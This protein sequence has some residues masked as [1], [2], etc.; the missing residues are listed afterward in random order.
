MKTLIYVAA[1]L[2]SVAACSKKEKPNCEAYA[3]KVA[4]L[5]AESRG[6]SVKEIAR[7]SCEKG[8]VSADE[9]SC[10]LA[11]TKAED[12]PRCH[13]APSN[14]PLSDK[15]CD[16]YAGQAAA[17]EGADKAAA[18]ASCGK[19]EIPAAEMRCVIE[20]EDKAAAATCHPKH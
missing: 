4:S 13:H 3:D 1:S 20:A 8:D 9:V 12:L 18:L 5:S 7:E 10:T 15:Q 16:L 14:K 17:L 2:A 6:A 19:G 11:T